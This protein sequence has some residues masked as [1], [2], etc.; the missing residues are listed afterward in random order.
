[1]KVIQNYT[2]TFSFVKKRIWDIRK[3]FDIQSQAIY[4]DTKLLKFYLF[5]FWIKN[6]E[7][8]PHI[9]EDGVSK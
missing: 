4:D 2:L 3:H 9:L 7:K 5:I 6:S 8:C 1:M